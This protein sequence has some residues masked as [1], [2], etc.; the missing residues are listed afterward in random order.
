[1][2]YAVTLMLKDDTESRIERIQAE[3]NEHLSQPFRHVRVAGP[4]CAGDGRRKGYMVLIEADRIE[5]AET[6][7]HESPIYRAGLHERAE[8]FEFQIQMGRIDG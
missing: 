2:L 3:L 7:L 5:D 1:M 6:Y 8:V 4:L